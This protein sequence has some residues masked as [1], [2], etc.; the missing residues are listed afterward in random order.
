MKAYLLAR[1]STDD[2]KDALPAQTIRLKDYARRKKFSYDLYE[3]QESAYSGDRTQ[4]RSIVDAINT[5][6]DRIAVVFDKIDRLTRDPTSD[7]YI[8]LVRLCYSG[9]IE[10]H[11][12]AD[13]VIITKD[14]PATDKM[15]LGFGVALA[16][17]YSAT[18]SDN[19][20]RRQAQMLHDGFWTGAAPFGY[21][22]TTKDGKKWLE[23]HPVNAEIIRYTFSSYASGTSSLLVLKSEWLDK[24]GVSTSH[25]RIEGLLKNPF[26]YGIM[27]VKGIHYEHNYERLVAKELFDQVQ[28]VLSGYAAKP[29]R[30]AGLPFAYRGLISC[31]E[32]GSRIT[33]ETKKNKY[34][35]GHCT[36]FKYKHDAKYINEVKLTEQFKSIIEMVKIPDDV[37]HELRDYISNLKTESISRIETQ[38]SL[39]QSQISRLSTRLERMYDDRLDDLISDEKYKE[40][41]HEFTEKKQL[42]ESDL[43]NIE[44]LDSRRLDDYSYLLD[45]ANKAPRLFEMAD[46]R[47]KHK[48]INKI[49]SNLQLDG[50][51]LRWKYKRPFNLM[52]FCNDNSTWQ[53]YVES[54][55]G[56]RFWRPTH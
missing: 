29:H 24:F 3:I 8:R 14:S 46:Y 50:S 36:Q 44:L 4:F 55:H 54:N 1:V 6:S 30:W 25:S 38:R 20:K 19:V 34:T 13:N 15:R 22:Y 11:F 33:F 56:F 5:E 28:A 35:Y 43:Q 2:Q 12:P 16:Q 10:L 37:L 21:Q 42:L 47:E 53:G 27:R 40:K 49:L 26:Y 48:I 32:C 18:I 41:Y 17:Y 52:A 39:L 51:L 7:E 9:S 31:S 45:L 23:P